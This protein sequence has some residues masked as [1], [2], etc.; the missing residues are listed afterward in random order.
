MPKRAQ[1]NLDNFTQELIE[2]CEK[3]DVHIDGVVAAIIATA[4]EE[5]GDV[6]GRCRFFEYISKDGVKE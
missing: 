6:E 2:L 4:Q 5:A 1:E 3:Y